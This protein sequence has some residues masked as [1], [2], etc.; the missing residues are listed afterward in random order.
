MDSVDVIVLGLG[1]MG[2]ATAMCGAASGA[3]I[4]AF[5]RFS[6]PHNYG[7]SHGRSRIFRQ[8]YFEDVRYVPLLL[9]AY[10][11][12]RK[13]EADCG[14]PLLHR[15]G[16]LVIGP[17][18]GEVVARSAEIARRFELPHALLSAQEIRHRF[19]VFHV[20]DDTHALLEYNAGYLVPEV[21]IAQQL[22]MAARSGAQLHLEEPVLSWE[23]KPGNGGVVVH[24]ARGSYAAARLVITAGPWAPE[25]LK[26]LQLPLRVTRQVLY[27][28]SPR[29]SMDSFRDDRLPVYLFEETGTEPL[30]YGF[31][32]TGPETEGVK[33]ALHGTEEP[34]T[35]ETVERALR[36][37]DEALI[38]RRLALAVPSLAGALLR[39]ETC[40]YTMTPDQHFVIGAHPAHPAVT[41]AAG[42]SGHGF[43]FATVIGEIMS[44]LALEGRTSHDISLFSPQRRFA[45]SAAADAGTSQAPSTPRSWTQAHD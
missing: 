35:P 11:L 14:E 40:L 10:D 23:A 26:Q 34:C 20:S 12:W 7:S 2:S 30:I 36:P 37:E 21:C 4:R 41:F 16:A 31:P 8:A 9:R 28:F 1:A 33:V 25:I 43:K 24:T 45:W 5:D 39:A 22:A 17:G 18:T 42:F 6:P 19:P 29:G 15:T 44:E 13:L 27:W 32:L 38:R 3:R